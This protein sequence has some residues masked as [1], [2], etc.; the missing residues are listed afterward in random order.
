MFG[1]LPWPN[2]KVMLCGCNQT[3]PSSRV[4]PRISEATK[5]D[6]RVSVSKF[7]LYK[8]MSYKSC[9]HVIPLV[10]AFMCNISNPF[11]NLYVTV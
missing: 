5:L 7:M 8:Y 3:K 1:F 9:N 6:L 2:A 11:K 10:N 4:K